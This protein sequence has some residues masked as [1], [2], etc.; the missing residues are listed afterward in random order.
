M[1][2]TIAKELKDCCVLLRTRVHIP[3]SAHTASPKFSWEASSE[4]MVMGGGLA[5]ACQLYIWGPSHP[6]Q[7]SFLTHLE[8]LPKLLVMTRV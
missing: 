5:S 3:T 2:E 4:Q 6:K 8:P 1:A 7:Q